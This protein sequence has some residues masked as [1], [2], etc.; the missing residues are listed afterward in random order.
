MEKTYDIIIGGGGIIG[1]MMAL[2]LSAQCLKIA[3]IDDNPI[4]QKTELDFDG[5]AYALSLST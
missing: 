3:L 4:S 5:R 2:A 1:S